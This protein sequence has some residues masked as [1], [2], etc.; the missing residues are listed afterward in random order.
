MPD[1]N[2]HVL[3]VA[4]GRGTRAAGYAGEL[5]KQ[6]R[7]IG[8]KA[9]IARTLDCFLAHPAISG[10][11]IVVH[12]ADGDA[13][14]AAT[15]GREG[16]FRAVTGGATRQI[17]V[18]HGL[19]SLAGDPPDAVLVHDCVRPFVSDAIID[20]AVAALAEHD[21]VLVATPVTDTLKSTGPGGAVTGTVPRDN[22][23]AAQTPQGFRFGPILAAHRKAAEAGRDDFTDDAAVAEWAGMTVHVVE[24]ERGNVKITTRE[25]IAMAEARFDTAAPVETRVGSGFDVHAFCAGDHVMLGGV[26][27]AHDHGLAGHSD[28]DVLLHA[29]TDAVLG[30]IALGDI[31]SHFPP[32][33]PQWRGAPSDIFLKHA[34]DRL[35]AKGGHLVHLDLTVIGEAPKVGPHREA[36]RERVAAICGVAVARVSVKATTT[37]KLGFT[38]R[39]EGLAAL[40]T[41]TVTVPTTLEEPRR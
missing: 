5:P 30:A 21:A 12:A 15:T 1:R 19:E 22:L 4:A 11:T 23:Y 39:R 33:D 29:A 20:R 34:C 31:G 37:E 17:S 28:A 10:V 2:V 25:D 13:L 3:L 38:G 9:V 36:I 16:R 27:I 41:A 32:S 35:W 40:A 26:R 14:V 8:G 7:V 24:G 18:R 6:Y